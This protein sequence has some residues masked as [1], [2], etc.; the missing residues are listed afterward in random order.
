MKKTLSIIIAAIA[1]F[2]CTPNL[3]PDV[4]PQKEDVTPA[5]VHVQAVEL[6]SASL[7]LLPGEKATLTA[8]VTPADATDMKIAWASSNDGVATVSSSG[9][10]TAVSPGNCIISATCDGK[11]ASCE[12]TV[13]RPAIPVESV[14]LD[15]TEANLL[16]GESLMLNAVVLPDDA[17]DKEITWTSSS[18]DVATVEN[19]KVTALSPGETTVTA[20]A[21]GISATCS[22]SVRAPFTYGGMC[23]EAVS[24]GT[25]VISNPLQIPIDYKIGEQDWTTTGDGTISISVSG[26]EKVWFRGRNESYAEVQDNGQRT[27]TISC[28]YGDFYLY[29]N[30]MSLVSGD[31][32]DSATTLTGEYAFYKLFFGN[33][34]IINHPAEEI[35]LPAT[36]LAPSCYRNM[37]FN[38]TKLTRAPKLPAKKLEE[39]CYASMF[40]GCSSLKAAPE[41]A[42][43][44]MAYM[45]CTWMMMQS[46]IE[47]APELPAMKL[48]QHC[49]EFMFMECQNLKTGPSVLPATELV[50]WCY[51]GMFQRCEKL[52]Q[53]PVLPATVMKNNC[54]SHMF[55]G[56]ASLK[57]APELPATVLANDC[58]ARMFGYSGLVEAPELPAMDLKTM[59]YAYMF[60]G[61]KSLEEAPVLPALNLDYWCYKE[62]FKDCTSLR[63]IKMLATK[64]I[65]ATWSGDR[66]FDLT[67]ENIGNY[68]TDWVTGVG[69][70]GTFVKNQ[71]ATWDM[72]GPDGVPEGWTIER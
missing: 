43:E 21:G 33:V 35:E 56:C 18:T 36:T 47:R 38:C 1:A 9:E 39:A 24:G 71:E 66:L 51:T 44:E 29:G 72:T 46:G 23:L 48:A 34:H 40:C 31:D 55:N 16:V 41:M 6:S 11:S 59:C 13:I 2:A 49:Y 50:T 20:T 57:R 4:I 32:Y 67:A 70:E 26:G 27:T 3:E 5:A 19:G 7:S 68:C 52:E 17:T 8:T 37:F 63:Y 25:I 61:C 58:Y 30:L 53:A 69:T 65:T 64:A 28:L 15:K 12:V 10:V 60:E 42:A 45:S 54:Y 62:M 14:S 22:V